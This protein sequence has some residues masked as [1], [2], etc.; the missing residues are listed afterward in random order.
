MSNVNSEPW[1]ASNQITR[2]ICLTSSPNRPS[3][4]SMNS[5]GPFMS[6]V[7]IRVFPHFDLLV[8]PLLAH[9]QSWPQN[10]NL[11]SLACRGQ[12]SSPTG[13][14]LNKCNMSSGLSP[15]FG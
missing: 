8:C 14:G 4:S 1:G 3:G 13:F 2:E 7:E 11:L 12:L 5:W 10:V 6:G 9:F 15:I